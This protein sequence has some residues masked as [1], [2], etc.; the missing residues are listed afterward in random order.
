M[1]VFFVAMQQFFSS[2]GKFFS[3]PLIKINFSWRQSREVRPRAVPAETHRRTSRAVAV[4]KS[5]SEQDAVVGGVHA[6][7]APSLPSQPS[8]LA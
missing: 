5:P 3:S 2:F 4:A 7:S 1:Q 6:A 8:L